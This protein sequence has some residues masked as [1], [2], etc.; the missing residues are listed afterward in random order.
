M[1]PPGQCPPVTCPQC[2]THEFLLGPGEQA[3]EV[4]IRLDLPRHQV[5]IA[6]AEAAL[7]QGRGAVVDVK[8]GE[9]FFL[10]TK[11]I[12]ICLLEKGRTQEI[13][14]LN[15][16][17][18]IQHQPDKISNIYQNYSSNTMMFIREKRD[19]CREMKINFFQQIM[20]LR[21]HVQTPSV[22]A[23]K[24]KLRGTQLQET[25]DLGE[26]N[27]PKQNQYHIQWIMF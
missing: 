15:G 23:K 27:C 16:P 9:I 26:L 7:V 17:R 6:C 11:K 8:L 13:F 5:I 1:C 24:G 18:S 4:R 14:F 19:N 10:K 21:K 2:L 20:N 22:S 3:N 12:N 25:I